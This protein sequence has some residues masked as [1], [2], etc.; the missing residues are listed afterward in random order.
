MWASQTMS[1]VQETSSWGSMACEIL[2]SF[3]FTL[4]MFIF[5][6]LN[7][8]FGKLALSIFGSICLT[9]EILSWPLITFG[10]L[11]WPGKKWWFLNDCHQGMM[12][13]GLPRASITCSKDQ[14]GYF[15]AERQASFS[16]PIT[17]TSFCYSSHS[18]S[19]LCMGSEAITE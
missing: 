15:L 5:S 12:E 9:N 8:K 19:L 10:E 2:L 1:V 13:C 14:E 11:A 4:H 6:T 17:R 7:L 3:D 18:I 16:C